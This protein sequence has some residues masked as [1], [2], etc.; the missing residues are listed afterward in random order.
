MSPIRFEARV[1]LI[2]S[3]KKYSYLRSL[4]FSSWSQMFKVMYNLPTEKGKNVTNFLLLVLYY[5]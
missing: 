1:L 2:Q 3:K 4:W 5:L